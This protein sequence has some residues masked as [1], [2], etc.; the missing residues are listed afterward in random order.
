MN[1]G[2]FFQ[3]AIGMVAMA[4][5]LAGCGATV[6]T[7][8]PEPSPEPAIEVGEVIFDGADC[9][10]SVPAELPIG[11]YSIVLKDFNEENHD[12]NLFVS[13]Q[14]NENSL[15]EAVEIQGEP[16]G[17]IAYTVYEGLFDDV[18]EPGVA[19]EKPDGGEVHTYILN[20]EGDYV[21]GI[22]IEIT[23]EMDKPRIWFCSPLHIKEPAS[24]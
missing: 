14:L 2:R 17:Y 11:K 22:W 18:I 4:V 9:T 8:T 7:P 1:R 13:Y 19:W 24:E 5:L 12:V 23:P 21:V 6:A 20:R 3:Q 16:G 10:D 15:Q